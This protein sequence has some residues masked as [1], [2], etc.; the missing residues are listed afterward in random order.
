MTHAAIIHKIKQETAKTKKAKKSYTKNIERNCRCTDVSNQNFQLKQTAADP[1]GDG[2][3]HHQSA[4][5][6]T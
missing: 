4:Q 6:T 1:R 3:E 2:S 5:N